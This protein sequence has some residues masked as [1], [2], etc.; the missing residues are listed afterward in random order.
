MNNEWLENIVLPKGHLEITVT[1]SKTGEIIR[2]DEGNNQ[3]QDWAK[4]SLAYMQAGRMFCTWGNHGE[5][6]NIGGVGAQVAH[7]RDGTDGTNPGDIVTQTPWTY[8][9][10]Y[11][12]LIQVR[13][14]GLDEP[15]PT[16][17][18]GTPLYPFF[19][20]KM[21]FGVGG[22]DSN[23]VPN[24]MDVDETQ[25]QNVDLDFPFVLIERERAAND[26]HIQLTSS[27]VNTINRVTFACRLPG[28]DASYPYNNKVISEA[29]LF[30]DAAVRVGQ[31]L[32]MRTGL[33]FA[34]RTFYG[35]NKNES[36]EIT[37]RWSF[38]F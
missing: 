29:G 8:N 12:G 32:S 1:D 17:P 25:L 23:Q 5:P 13:N 20:T 31:D 18:A 4:H 9:D 34:Y 7:Y 37:F 6:Y 35:I 14:D 24:T 2:K 16:A 33:M 10:A 28:G 21:R 36:I 30:C 19:P 3:I 27:G 15:S 26:P 22:L 11:E 38:L